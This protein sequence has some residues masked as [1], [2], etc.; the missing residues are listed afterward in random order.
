[1]FYKITNKISMS[2]LMIGIPIILDFKLRKYSSR[3]DYA[4]YSMRF[5]NLRLSGYK[6][7]SYSHLS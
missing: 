4:K 3:R 6:H 2:I 5:T 7:C 1:M